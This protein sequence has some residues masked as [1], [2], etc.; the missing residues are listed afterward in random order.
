M[1]FVVTICFL[2]LFSLSAQTSPPKVQTGT[3]VPS[4]SLSFTGQQGGD[5]AFSIQ[6]R[7]GQDIT[8][9]MLLL[10]PSGVPS[11]NGRY[12]CQSKCN[13][14]SQI[15]TIDR[16]AI[17]VGASYSI[18][19]PVSQVTDGAVIFEAAIFDDGSYGG[20]ER[21]AAVLVA[22]QL[23]HQ[24][25]F[26][27]IVSIIDTVLANSGPKSV[28]E[29]SQIGASLN[30]LPVD[31]DSDE[32]AA[33]IRWFPNV[34]DCANSFPQLMQGLASTEKDSV[35]SKLQEFLNTSPDPTEA[36]L[37]NWW[38][39]TRQYLSSFGCSGCGAKLASPNP[40]VRTRTV[41]V[42][43]SGSIPAV[44]LEATDDSGSDDTGTPDSSGQ[45]P[46]D[47]NA[48]DESETGADDQLA[49][50]EEPPDEV[51]PSAPS[52]TAGGATSI[53]R[54]QSSSRCLPMP[55]RPIPRFRAPLEAVTPNHKLAGT[56]L[57]PVLDGRLYPRYFRY[58]REWDRCLSSD[59][60]PPDTAER[61]PSPYPATL[62]D[63]QRKAVLLAAREWRGQKP[64]VPAQEGAQS[65]TASPLSAHRVTPPGTW[66]QWQQQ[67]AFA[68]EQRQRFAKQR[69]ETENL[70]ESQLKQL[71]AQIGTTSF[72]GL[73]NYAHELYHATPGKP[74][75][76]PLPQTTI[77]AR[78]FHEISAF[79]RFAS[80][81]GEDGQDAAKARAE[82][83]RICGLTNKEQALL[84]Q[85]AQDF[86]QDLKKLQPQSTAT[87]VTSQSI[88]AVRAI[89]LEQRNQIA[90]SHI[91][92]LHS[93][94]SKAGFEKIERRA[95]TLYDSEGAELIVPVTEPGPEPA[96]RSRPPSSQ[97]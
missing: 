1:K 91:G 43:C 38:A 39:A 11:S 25:E 86:E 41:S 87:S 9:F 71:R 67:A 40:P 56:D 3:R 85:E 37:S 21:A 19:Y 80:H 4:V 84:L 29:A 8:A 31:A 75:H 34:R 96:T 14:T 94:L 47:G 51:V 97:N 53:A 77:F 45:A 65:A 88:R 36:A 48:S 82:E 22:N 18:A 73:D 23:G 64:L 92:R 89:P 10:V 63:D 32:M 13:G 55:P 5:Y 93:S 70:I 81:E 2:F 30:G 28:P 26:D 66:A 46:A 59:N 42:G 33:F 83:Q 78:Y 27:R 62:N 54:S 69:E 57:V 12:L 20:N 17:K 58:V 16:P 72:R 61:Y 52:S 90:N 15:G 7:S 50:T 44:L 24:T 95:H 60:W 74:V 6:N 79:E 35:Q 76:E 49:M 68:K